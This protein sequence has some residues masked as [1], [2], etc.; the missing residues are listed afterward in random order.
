MGKAYWRSW[1]RSVARILALRKQTFEEW[2]LEARKWSVWTRQSI[3]AEAFSKAWRE[4]SGAKALR[5]QRGIIPRRVRRSMC[6]DLVKRKL[7]RRWD[8]QKAMFNATLKNIVNEKAL[9]YQTLVADKP[10]A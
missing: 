5:D 3:R 6:R 4:M 7:G 9:P 10:L 2:V 8:E 1:K